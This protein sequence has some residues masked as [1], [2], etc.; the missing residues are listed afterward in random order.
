[1]PARGALLGIDHGSVRIGYALTDEGQSLAIPLETWA[2]RGPRLDGAHLVEI[3]RDYRIQGLVIGLPLFKSGDESPQAGIVRQFGT[4]AH[5]LS[6]LPVAYCD[7]RHSSTEAEVL[8]MSRGDSPRQR[9]D[10]LDR[11]A[12]QFILQT[13]LAQRAGQ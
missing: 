4:W 5:E 10:K 6:G 13:Y 2:V 8:L 1:M 11:L 9:K 7:E 12:A 3:I